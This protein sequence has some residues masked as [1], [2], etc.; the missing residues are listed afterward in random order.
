MQQIY[1]EIWKTKRQY[2]LREEGATQADE[3]SKQ[4]STTPH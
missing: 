1:K 3:V 4:D 2:H